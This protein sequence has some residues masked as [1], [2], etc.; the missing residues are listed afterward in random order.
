MIYPRIK[1]IGKEKKWWHSNSFIA[2]IEK[3][4]AIN[5]GDGNG[6]KLILFVNLNLN[7]T[8]KEIL[9]KEINDK[10]KELGIF[11]FEIEN[12]SLSFQIREVL[13]PAKKEKILNI[14]NFGTELLSK[15]NIKRSDTCSECGKAE[16][17]FAYSNL[18]QINIP[19]CSH[20]L[21]NVNHYFAQEKRA[22]ETEDKNYLQGF[23]GALIFAIPAIMLWVLFAVFL[24]IITG[25]TALLVGFLSIKGYEKFNGKVGKH[26]KW[27]LIAVNILSVLIANYATTAFILYRNKLNLNDI[28][29]N[30]FNNHDIIRI[31]KTQFALSAIVCFFVWI[32]LF[33]IY[34][35]N[36]Q[37]P[38]YIR[39]EQY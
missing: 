8:E 38:K 37:F 12:D 9:A 15:H 22:F 13:I 17:N 27:I 36:S 33:Y 10:K 35:K 34:Y 29:Y 3:N 25:A 28:I 5:L 2:G 14:I 1:S 7:E 24:D 21:I 23:L 6:F 11:L 19:L 18:S 32:W 4:Y 30:I 31:I 16:F 39:S 26:Q 20:C